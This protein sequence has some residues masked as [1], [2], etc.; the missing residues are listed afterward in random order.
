MAAR[1]AWHTDTFLHVVGPDGEP[2][3]VVGVNVESLRENERTESFHMLVKRDWIRY[4]GCYT[5]DIA[6]S[7]A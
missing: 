7:T 5:T 3:D 6:V 1:G 4:L 2:L